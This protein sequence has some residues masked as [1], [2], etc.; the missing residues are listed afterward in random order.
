MTVQYSPGFMIDLALFDMKIPEKEYQ[1]RIFF[2]ITP[3]LS[4]FSATINNVGN[5]LIKTFLCYIKSSDPL[6]IFSYTKTSKSKGNLLHPTIK[7]LINLA[8]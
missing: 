4:E 7:R 5:I 1:F 3:L 8:N 6:K 2:L